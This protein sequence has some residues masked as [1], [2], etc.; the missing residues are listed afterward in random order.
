D[1]PTLHRVEPFDP[2]GDAAILRKAMKGFGTDEDAI[3]ALLSKRTSDQRHQ[4]LLKYNQVYNDRDCIKDLKEE[5]HG[6]FEQAIVALMRPMPQYLAQ[7]LHHAMDGIG[8]KER[9]LVEILCSLNNQWIYAIKNAYYKE[10]QKQLVDEIKDDASGDFK[11]LLISMCDGKRDERNN[12]PALANTIAQQ[13]HTAGEARFGTNESEFRRIMTN[14]SYPLLKEVFE[15]YKKIEGHEFSKAIDSEL[16]GSFKKGVMAIYDIVENRPAFFAKE[17]HDC[18]WGP[19]TADRTLI[20]LVLV[21]S[22]IDMQNIK[23]EYLKMYNKTLVDA[24]K[25]DTSGDYKKLLIALVEG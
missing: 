11:K 21:R 6:H 14:Y 16:S 19:G 2:S 15:E 4:I 22:E 20:R 1:K 7:E 24:I 25:G 5:L 23:E 17:L 13:L 18:M 12:D 10:Y 9:T 3:I 8:T